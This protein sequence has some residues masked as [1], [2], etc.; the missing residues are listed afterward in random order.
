MT[1]M[2]GKTVL[3]TGATSGIGEEAALALAKLGA[4]VVVHGRSA[5][6]GEATLV[7]IRAEVPDASLEFLQADLASLDAVRAAAQ[8]FLASDRPLDVLLNNAGAMHT[9]RKVT[10][11]GF[12][13]TF[14]VN[15]L[16]CFAL[17]LHLLPALKAAR[18]ARV[19]SVA[20]EAHRQA[21][22]G[23]PWDDLQNEAGYSAFRVYAE[24]KLANILFARELARRL[25]GTGITSNSLHPG[26]VATGFARNDAG[27]M[28][29]LWAA[30]AVFLRSP[31]KG[32][33]TSIYL[34]SSPDVAGVT[35]QYFS[36]S[37]TKQPSR[38]G[39]SDEDALRLWT[40]S[41]ELT[42]LSLEAGQ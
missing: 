34:A 29:T 26:V 12:E 3:V 6:K 30:L 11:D 23:M 37:K 21:T 35:G 32:A 16:A 14:G 31:A 4:H 22:R 17:T 25:E 13:M 38:F 27:W 18:G 5:E 20:S 33:A 41:E 7:R 36:N 39:R 42:G 40:A 28:S 9:T 2:S 10:A 1:E 8:G 15:H 24:S 19:V